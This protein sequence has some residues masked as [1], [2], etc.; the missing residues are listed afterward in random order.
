MQIKGRGLSARQRKKESA[1][2]PCSD[3]HALRRL[4]SFLNKAEAGMLGGSVNISRTG[5]Y[6]AYMTYNPILFEITRLFWPSRK[7][8]PN[9]RS[10]LD[11][12]KMMHD[13]DGV[14]RYG[15]AATDAQKA[16]VSSTSTEQV[17]EKLRALLAPGA[18]REPNAVNASLVLRGPKRKRG[19]AP[20]PL[21]GPEEYDIKGAGGDIRE[22]IIVGQDPLGQPIGHY[23]PFA[24]LW[25][26]GDTMAHAIDSAVQF[27]T[28]PISYLDHIKT[29][30]LDP[31]LSRVL[32]FRSSGLPRPPSPL[33]RKKGP[34]SQVL[35]EVRKGKRTLD[36]REPEGRSAH[37]RALLRGAL[38]EAAP[39]GSR[40]Q[41]TP[42]TEE[43]LRQKLRFRGLD[44]TTIDN[45]IAGRRVAEAEALE[46]FQRSPGN[47]LRRRQGKVEKKGEDTRR[48]VGLMAEP[49]RKKGEPK[50]WWTPGSLP[51]DF[52]PPL[53]YDAA[54]LRMLEEVQ[55]S[56]RRP[57]A[58]LPPVFDDR[59]YAKR[60]ISGTADQAARWR[61]QDAIY[62]RS[63][64]AR[65][66]GERESLAAMME[67]VE[68]AMKNLDGKI[69]AEEKRKAPKKAK[70]NRS[71]RP[72]RS[73]H[74][75]RR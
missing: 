3:L 27:A 55:S 61:G 60:T 32:H 56:P 59:Y 53:K 8:D 11:Q 47:V 64:L 71:R 21:E 68:K 33:G 54:T 5:N 4:G 22:R 24:L 63:A 31:A 12:P 1:A 15:S 14:G 30:V 16:A 49:L 28:N 6:T 17:F 44:S 20:E 23:T 36:P 2:G 51:P 41:L 9:F 37:A 65:A 7:K 75:R 43:D 10:L 62:E 26:L 45:I 69:A 35:R 73:S 25:P 74:R 38:I 13:I 40:S 34:G 19:Q 50:E 58:T 57:P 29:T 67:S 42:D 72:R 48:W 52:Q 46:R 70:K 39:P 18:G 66:E